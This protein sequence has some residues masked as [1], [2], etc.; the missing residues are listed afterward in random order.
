M[1]ATEIRD[2]PLERYL[3]ALELLAPHA[4][5]LTAPELER[6]MG[7]P[8]ASVNRIVHVLLN[9]GLAMQSPN[10]ARAFQLGPRILHLLHGANDTSWLERI[11]EPALQQLA[12]ATGQSAFI[13]RINADDA[14]IRSVN[15]VSP[16]T[17]V[18]FHIVPGT[19]M[20]PNASASAKAILAHT[21][22]PLRDRILA[23]EFSAFTP[24][25][26]LDRDSLMED[27]E[28][29]RQRGYAIETGEHVFGLASIAMPV[30]AQ[31]NEVRYAVGLTGPENGILS[32]HFDRNIALLTETS[33]K[34]A[35][36]LT[37]PMT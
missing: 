1:A 7:L 6:A 16:D 13:A 12:E 30:Y 37:L 4:D 17:T 14:E 28:Q 10:R 32:P 15:C 36:V 8:K 31:N 19:L 22:E 11:T 2:T 27:L 5:G 33:E 29:V 9:S 20:P 18:R 24:R 3:S 26:F 23:R 21:P 34:L 35:R 25:T